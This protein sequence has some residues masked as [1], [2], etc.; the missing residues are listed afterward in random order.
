[1][2]V[3]VFGEAADTV[4]AHLALGAIDVEHPHADISVVGREDEDE[5]VGADAAMPVADVAG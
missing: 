5:A 1:M 4:T 2:I 3:G